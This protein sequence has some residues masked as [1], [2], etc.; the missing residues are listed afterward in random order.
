[1]I[2]RPGGAITIRR[3]FDFALTAEWGLFGLFAASFLAATVL[4]GGSE[5]ALFAVVRAYP[6][7]VFAALVVATVGNTL[8]GMSTYLL[9]RFMAQRALPAKAA[10]VQRWG[11]GIL[12]LSWV[13]LVGDALCLAAGWL[14]LN[15][16]ASALWMGVGKAARYGAIIG[17]NTLF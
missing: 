13:P 1:M 12:L 11:S 15:W 9:G 7:Q 16:A 8:G 14:R 17:L 5:A 3:M 6:D 2:S 10:W 4:P